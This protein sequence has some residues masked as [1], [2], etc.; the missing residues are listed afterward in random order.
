MKG[1][2]EMNWYVFILVYLLILNIIGAVITI[3]DKKMARKGRWRTPEATLF[4]VCALGGSV[5]MY[6]TM[7]L[8]RHKTKKKKFMV[9]IPVV[10]FLQLIGAILLG[11]LISSR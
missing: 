5:G 7:K 2:E 6:L 3:H 9:G 1:C 10:F 8:I 4:A 11:F